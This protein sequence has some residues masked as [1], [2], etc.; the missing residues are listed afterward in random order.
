[1]LRLCMVRKQ[2]V[3][4][5]KAK[6]G[7]QSIEPSVRERRVSVSELWRRYD[8]SE[9]GHDGNLYGVSGL[10][11]AFGFGTFFRVTPGGDFTT[12]HSFDFRSRALSLYTAGLQC[13]AADGSVS[14]A[15][16]A[17]TIQ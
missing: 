5:D 11:G 16:A 12:L 2:S 7:A 15:G 9:N 1:M 10:G 6:F 17:V 8:W 3:C 13:T 4:A 14:N